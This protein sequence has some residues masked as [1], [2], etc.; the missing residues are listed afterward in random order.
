VR[1]LLLDSV[2]LLVLK[3]L[4][5]RRGLSRILNVIDPSLKVSDLHLLQSGE[6]DLRSGLLV[7][8]SLVIEI[9]SLVVISTISCSSIVGTILA[10]RM[11][12]GTFETS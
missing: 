9:G 4:E 2:E 7:P 3:Y 8:S 10:L 1:H 11:V 12:I 5:Y 6:L